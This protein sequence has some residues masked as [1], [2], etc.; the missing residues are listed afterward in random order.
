MSATASPLRTASILGLV[1]ALA[2]A[3]LGGMYLL[4]REPIE[5]AQ[6]SARLATILALIPEGSCDNDVLNDH[7]DVLAEASLGAPGPLRIYRAR[8]LGKP[9][10]AVLPVV[11]PDGYSGEIAML[12][13]I[14]WS[15]E[16]TGVR[17]IAH[18][19]TPGLGD[20][21]EAEKSD[22][23][24]GFN[25]RSLHNTPAQDWNVRRDGGKF[26]QFAGATL[27]PR[28]VVRAVHRALEYF[29][30]NRAT[31]FGSST[32]AQEWP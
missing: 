13:G 6:R 22:W 4:T 27:T 26:D 30:A 12:V 2:S 5:Q 18:R 29:S 16:L 31:L 15:G 19:E 8:S 11:A 3:A 7:V 9:S 1:A 24:L 25:G 17:V 20:W 21:I 10:V 23:I 32:S 28:A 14:R